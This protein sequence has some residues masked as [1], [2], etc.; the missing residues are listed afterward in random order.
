MSRELFHLYFGGNQ[1]VSNKLPDDVVYVIL[2]F[3]NPEY[4]F[5][6][7][8]SPIQIKNLKE[9][10]HIFMALLVA[11]IV[12]KPSNEVV[13]NDV[14]GY[15]LKI[16]KKHYLLS[17]MKWSSYHFEG[18]EGCTRSHVDTALQILNYDCKSTH[19]KI[20]KDYRSLRLIKFY[21]HLSVRKGN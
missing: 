16:L 14:V 11:D 4:V 3:L 15:V 9:Y 10:K 6:E 5:I 8:F 1:T 18:G 7:R 21:G 13:D 2:N 19:L 12:C 20:P 17:T